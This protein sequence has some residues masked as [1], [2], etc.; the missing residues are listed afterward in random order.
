MQTSFTNNAN[1]LIKHIFKRSRD[2]NHLNK[3]TFETVVEKNELI[4]KSFTCWFIS[5]CIISGD[6]FREG[7][8]LIWSPP[9]QEGT[10]HPCTCQGRGSPSRSNPKVRRHVQVKTT[11]FLFSVFSQV[12]DSNSLIWFVWS[13][14]QLFRGFQSQRWGR[15]IK[16]IWCR[17][18]VSDSKLDAPYISVF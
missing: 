6:F 3:L 9:T 8:L 18:S 13:E 7:G 17:K 10:C 11:K 1:L 12:F 14:L 15:L 2:K 16:W 4:L 5:V